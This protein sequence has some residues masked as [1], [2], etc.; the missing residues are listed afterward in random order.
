MDQESAVLELDPRSVLAAI[1]QANQAVD[2]WEKGTVGAGDRMQKALER[3]AE[4]L[5]KMNDKS[6]SSMERLTQ[7]I[8]KQ[9]AAYGKTGVERLVAERDRMIK[10]LGDEKAMVDRV[11]AAYDKM[12]SAERGGSGGGLKQLGA[13]ARESK[14]SLALMGEE[15]GVHIPRHIRGFIAA[16]PGVGS[17]LNAAF[18]AVAVIALIGVIYEAIK[19]VIEFREQMEQLRDAPQKIAAEFLRLNDATRL[20]NEE[21]QLTNTR[22]ENSIAKLQ[23]KPENLLKE[24]IHE[25]AI[26]AEQLAEKMDKAL[27]SFADVAIKNAPGTFANIVGGQVGIDDIVKLIQGKSG[28][29]GLVGDLY[30]VTSSGGDPREVLGQY[31]AS[32][33]AM[34]R[35]SEFAQA[36]QQGKGFEGASYEDIRG[37]MSGGGK[38]PAG[39]HFQ[40]MLADQGPRLETLRA[41]QQQ[42]DLLTTSYELE[43]KHA[44]LTE[45]EKQL[46][47]V[48]KATDTTEEM[49][50][51]VAH[52]QE[53]EL[54]GLDKINAAYKERLRHLQ[55]EG[56]LNTMNAALAKQIRDAEIDRFQKEEQRKTSST[57]FGANTSISEAQIRG[58]QTVF[59]AGRKAAGADFGMA[60]IDN[61]YS[62]SLRLAQVQF[63]VAAQHVKELRAA[64]ASQ[65]DIE[66]AQIEATKN[67]ALAALD[68]ETKRRV[69]LI[70]LAKQQ[71]DEESKTAKSN[72]DNARRLTDANASEQERHDRDGLQRQIKMAEAMGLK[73]SGGQATT[74]ATVEQLRIAAAQ[75]QHDQAVRRLNQQTSEAEKLPGN[76]PEERRQRATELNNLKIEGIKVEGELQRQIDDAHEDRVI[77]T[78]EIQEREMDD[79]KAKSEGLLH[80]LFTKP[81]NFGKQLRETTRE[82]VLKPVTEGLGGMFATA[83]HPLIY[84]SDGQGGIA[85]VFRGVFGGNKQDP[86]KVSTDLNSAVTA[87]NSAAVA[88]LT[89]VLAGAMGMGMPAVAAP[90]GVGGISVPG[91]SAPSIAGAASTIISGGAGSGGSSMSPSV[92][93]PMDPLAM[94]FGGGADRNAGSGGFPLGGTPPFVGG[95]TS[96]SGGASGGNSGF[97]IAGLL[98]NFKSIKLGGLTRSAPV[99]GTDEDGN[100]SQVGGGKVNGV[101]GLAGAALF[102]GGM[103]AAQQGLMGSWRGTWGGVAAGTL[104]GAAMGFQMGG[105]LGAAIGAAAG[106]GIGIGEK[107][108][109]V[110]SPENEAKRLIKQLY[111]VNID[112]AMAKQ[113]V[114]IAQQK[115]AGHV[116]IAVRDP[117]VRKML[118]LY[119]QGTGQKMPLSA[120]TPRAGS[121]AEVNGS[122][123]QQ[124]SY[125]NGQAYSFQSPLPVMGG[126]SSGTYP[127]PT[128]PNSGGGMGMNFSLNINGQQIT[129]EFVADQ[130]MAAQGSS[131]GRTQQAANMQVP[132]LMVA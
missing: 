52:A 37:A 46:R 29:G 110:E 103:M 85:G 131:Y 25:A 93:R 2:S 17:A 96:S 99:Y 43:K 42:I 76:T 98:K 18:S 16:M 121:I 129:P 4:M 6:R 55:Q 59:Q 107:I 26:E 72:Y 10:K 67:F 50:Q 23:H 13:E 3:Q 82:A 83:I 128:G 36:Y 119:A 87:Q 117:D 118:E 64:N 125:V 127:T 40:D 90:A 19:K 15:M 39:L 115:Y 11:T 8:E 81:G 89:A 74:A 124:L 65:G 5:L 68:A 58:N 33:A 49:R 48:A 130:S 31:R 132:G 86:M 24:A 60:D 51:Q 35:Q 73:T 80:T 75:M 122:L 14:A 112:T 113:I 77:K 53:G 57:L 9:A 123:Y 32:V 92:N 109:G 78:M 34:T 27:R 20:H 79:L 70:D 7:S 97:G 1:K 12:I 108:A 120:A 116:S 91:I 38:L 88:A 28:Y 45:H 30:K 104:G 62:T 44:V 126:L 61:E 100:D 84:G 54:N 63:D 22:L 41:L 69:Q 66:R 47:D 114:S 106:F 71:R 94:I 56:Q 95:G 105:P 21:L 111:G 102:T 101:N